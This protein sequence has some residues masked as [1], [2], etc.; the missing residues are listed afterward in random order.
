MVI[1]VCSSAF[2]VRFSQEAMMNVYYATDYRK[3]VG[4][5][6]FAVYVLCDIS[7]GNRGHFITFII[8]VKER[9]YLSEYCQYTV[10]RL[11][12]K[13]TVFH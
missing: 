2:P 13:V 9:F 12:N 6:C 7:E 1:A 3:K 8:A 4:T 5:Y 11:G 10:Q